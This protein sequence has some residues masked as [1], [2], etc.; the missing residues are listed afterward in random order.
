MTDAQTDLSVLSGSSDG[1]APS[2][3]VA[4][5]APRWKTRLLLP[6]LILL[7]VVILLLLSSA[8]ALLPAT[9]V[10]VIPAVAKTVA[11]GGGAVTVQAPGWLEPDPHPTY[12][13][14]LADGVVS[15]LLVLEGSRVEAD[16]VVARLV[17]DDA[18]LALDRA[19]A[20]LLQRRSELLA[21]GARLTAAQLKLEHLIERDQ[22]VAEARAAVAEARAEVIKVQ[23][24]LAVERAVYLE[25]QDEYDRKS[26]LTGTSAVAEATVARL[27]LRLDAQDA[28]ID[29]AVAR[30]AVVQARLAQAE[31]RHQAAVIHRELLIEEREAVSLTEAAV[32]TAEAAVKLAQVARDEAALRLDRMEVRSPVAGIVMRRL[33]SP[34]SKLMREGGEHS[35]HVVH[36]YDPQRLQVRVDVPLADAAHVAIGQAVEVTVEVLPDRVFTGSV[37]RLVHE[38]DIQ[39]NTVEVKVAI[40]D[41]SSELKPDML[42]RA[43]F[44]ARQQ[45]PATG[46][47][48]QRVFAPASLVRGRSGGE[49][50]SAL[51]V[52]GL[53]DQ[54][55]RVEERSIVTGTRRLGGWI[56]VESGLQI[57][58]LLIA[59]AP[60]DLIAGDRVEVIGEQMVEVG[61]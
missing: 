4:A 42:A 48:R 61:G 39:K 19:D 15:E 41:P 23:A 37:T 7:S 18:R 24:D 58:D 32:G 34:G 14:A 21:A 28:S 56:E 12:I 30:E 51:I 40:D 59:D 33:A 35:A 43:R 5:P 29:A 2:I 44:L 46:S 22:A 3:L 57:G 10:R 6:G 11:G 31:A 9:P 16:E 38:A 52:T 27:R 8:Q 45:P 20:A 26:K 49:G 1:T 13:A 25:L 54:R 53:V 55:G 17:D 36:L 47:A 60:P 50:A